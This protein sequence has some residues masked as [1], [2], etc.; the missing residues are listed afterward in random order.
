MKT[1]F[2]NRELTHVYAQQTQEYGRS[3]SMFF[4]GA[5]IYSYGYHY[6]IA[7]FIDNETILINDTGYSNT[8]SKHISLVTIA[9][10]HKRQFF[11]TKTE[12]TEVHYAI[13][14]YF[15]KLP[16]ARENKEYY[17]K[18]I[19]NLFKT[20][21]K[22]LEYT[23]TKTKVSKLKEYKEIKKIVQRLE[24]EKESILKQVAELN[25]R[26]A[27]RQKEKQKEQIELW[28]NHKIRYI[29]KLS[30]SLLRLSLDKKQI[31]TSGGVNIET[32]KAKV[33]YKLIKAGKDIK[34][35]KLDYYTVIG[36]QGNILKIGCH[37]IPLSEVQSIGKQIVNL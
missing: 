4:E 28:R 36:I 22:Y 29:N 16:K 7:K 17:L 1:V 31:E 14:S 8:T 2:S 19:F 12:L 15:Q 32:K 3:G 35:F 13:K 34:G 6:L 23:K 26:K 10:S 21:N 20:F 33:L 37:N 27:Q 5:K 25:K 30:H 18:E 24:T 9:T 11:K